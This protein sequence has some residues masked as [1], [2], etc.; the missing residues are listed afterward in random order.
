NPLYLHLDGDAGR[1][2]NTSDRIDRD[3]VW[4]AK[5]PALEQAF[6]EFADSSSFDRY[7]NEQGD[8]LEGF[9]IYSAIAEVHDRMWTE[10]PEELRSPARR[11]VA[12]YAADHDD[13]VRFH[14]WLQWRLDEQLAAAGSEIGLVHDLAIGVDPAGADAW[15]W[16]DA[17]ALSVRVGAPPDEFNSAGQDWGLPPFNPWTLRLALYEPFIQTVRAGFRHA[18][19]LRFDHVMGLFR[20]WWIPE[21][22]SA[23][24]GVYVRYPAKEMLDILALESVRAGG[25]VVGEDL[26]TVEPYVRHELA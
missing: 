23:T 8:A 19:G 7:R 21:N 24:D 2:L 10:W 4:E 17:F 16:Q 5:M 18:A 20:L 9:A 25:Y 6:K 13:R 26:G 3:A 11:E 12:Q 15:L 1:G 22:G 14:Q